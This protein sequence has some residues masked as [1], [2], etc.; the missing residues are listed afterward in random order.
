VRYPR[1]KSPDW[2]TYSTGLAHNDLFVSLA[3]MMDVQTSTFGNAAVCKGPLAGLA[4]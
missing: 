1:V 3:N 2:P 4:S